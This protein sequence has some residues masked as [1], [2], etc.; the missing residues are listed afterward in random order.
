MNGLTKKLLIL[1]LS[2]A[3]STPVLAD[4]LSREEIEKNLPALNKLII[5]QQKPNQFLEVTNVE[6]G[7]GASFVYSAKIKADSIDQMFKEDALKLNVCSQFASNQGG[8]L[9]SLDYIQYNFIDVSGEVKKSIKVTEGDC[10]LVLANKPSIYNAKG[11]YT[12]EYIQKYIIEHTLEGKD[13]FNR[14][15]KDSMTEIRD[16][17]LGEGSSYIVEYAVFDQLRDVYKSADEEVVQK[18]SKQFVSSMCN[19]QLISAQ[20]PYVDYIQYDIYDK[21]GE[22]EAKP[23]LHYIIS[24]KDCDATK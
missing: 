6:L 18:L 14:S 5:S 7:E 13:A 8:I 24:A 22:A 21:D 12:R 11:K 2:A 15:L 23:L 4:K 20:L 1:A 16:L 19:Q 17:K 10:N 9:K 3:I